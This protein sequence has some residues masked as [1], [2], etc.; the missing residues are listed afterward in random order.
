[1]DGAPEGLYG[2]PEVYQPFALR[3]EEQEG[4]AL[5]V[6]TLRRSA[7]VHGGVSLQGLLVQVERVADL[8][9]FHAEIGELF[10]FHI[11]T[12]V[13]GGKAQW[14]DQDIRRARRNLS[15]PEAAVSCRTAHKL[16][17]DRTQSAAS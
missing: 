5:R 2:R 10:P 9:G 8:G 12:P 4:V 7:E 6:T 14:L 16:R 13:G 17:T 15:R 3:I 1:M 11:G